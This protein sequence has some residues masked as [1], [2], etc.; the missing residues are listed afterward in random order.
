VLLRTPAFEAGFKRIAHRGPDSVSHHDAALSWGHVSMS[1]C[2]LAITGGAHVEEASSVHTA[3]GDL[4]LAFNGE[5]YNW[6][7]LRAG[8]LRDY[9]WRTECD[10]EVVLHAWQHWGEHCVEFFNGMFAFV[11]VDPKRNLV[12]AARDRAGE[13]PLYIAE[14]KGVTYLAS[15]IKALPIDLR[16]VECQDLEAL[17]FDFD[18]AT[19]FHS[20]TSV[21]PGHTLRIS[22]STDLRAEYSPYWE[23]P[24]ID[25]TRHERS[26]KHISVLLDDITD[27]LVDAIRIR[28]RTERPLAALV[29]G[30][31]D[32]AIIQAV[33]GAEN[34]Y[35]VAFDDEQDAIMPTAYAAANGYLHN[36]RTLRRIVF[37]LNGAKTWL[38]D[39]AYHLDTPATWTA[40]AQWFL[41]K[42]IRADLGHG[43]V[44]LTGEGADETFGGY[45]RY[46][47]LQHIDAMRD[48][49]ALVDYLPLEHHLFGSDAT[50]LTRLLDRSDGKHSEHVR[51]IVGRVIP[52]KDHRAQPSLVRAAM[53][54]DWHTT[55]Q[56]LLRMLD[57]MMMA[58]ALEARCPFL[59]H[60]VVE[61]TAQLPAD[62]LVGPA[63]TKLA[64]REIARRLGVHRSITEETRKRGFYVPWNAWTSAARGSRG[65]WDRSD[66]AKTMRQ[67]W[68]DHGPA[69]RMRANP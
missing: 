5:I 2:R 22:T 49:P 51:E 64:L 14:H 48:D 9:V 26:A 44:V 28:A 41:A 31:L 66:F 35:T 62:L 24:Q 30:G 18:R 13:K 42:Q 23:L 15:E 59:D 27:E 61:L 4:Q 33:T 3:L 17:E 69:G 40:I 60:R 7:D 21:P 67:A 32:S 34:R 29:S 10:A 45:S 56:C 46:K 36:G 1:V 63:G 55:M 37:T 50:L 39:I 19:P 20:V 57:R 25:L 38:P 16:E 8:P 12:F 58:H 11:L 54:L 6:R 53:R 65:A 52:F 43:T 68:L 47:V